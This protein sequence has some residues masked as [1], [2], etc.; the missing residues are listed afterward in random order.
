MS[1]ITYLVHFDLTSK[2]HFNITV[3][4]LPG[5]HAKATTFEGALAAAKRC[6]EAHLKALGKAGKAIPRESRTTPP[7]C[8]HVSVNVPN[9][10]RSVN[11]P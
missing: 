9:A 5:C 1:Q 10:K 3:P 2:G 6:I 4:K 7:L 8:L 11:H